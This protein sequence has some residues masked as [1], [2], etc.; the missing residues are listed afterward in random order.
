MV[1]A[2]ARTA[3]AAL[4][5]LLLGVVSASAQTIEPITFAGLRN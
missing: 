3:L 2:R 4:I 1:V 5:T